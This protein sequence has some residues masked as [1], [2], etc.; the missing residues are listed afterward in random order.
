MM[1][2]TPLATYYIYTKST[3]HVVGDKTISTGRDNL[4][5][6]PA[7]NTTA[8]SWARSL[9]RNTEHGGRLSAQEDAYHPRS[10]SAVRITITS[11]AK[12]LVYI[13]QETNLG[14]TGDDSLRAPARKRPW[15]PECKRFRFAAGFFFNDADDCVELLAGGE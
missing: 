3:K 11:N 14:A 9:A 4:C 8:G 6:C 1:S 12:Q 10:V 2:T 5:L 15:K 13:A 7:R